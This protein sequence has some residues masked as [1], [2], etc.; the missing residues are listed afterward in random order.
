MLRTSVFWTCPIPRMETVLDLISSFPQMQG[1]AVI[2][3]IRLVRDPI[4]RSKELVHHLQILQ[5]L[6]KLA[7]LTHH[8]R[9]TLAS[10]W[11]ASDNPKPPKV[12][13][14]HGRSQNRYRNGKRHLREEMHD[15]GDVSYKCKNLSS[16][17]DSVLRKTWKHATAQW[18]KLH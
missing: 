4:Y 3:A 14:V 5:E 10:N 13:V 12:E 6:E 1:E 11:A 15:F 17:S 2:S 7:K 8:Q 9:L 18:V 16:G